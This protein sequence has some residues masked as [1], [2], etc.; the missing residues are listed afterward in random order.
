MKIRTPAFYGSGVVAFAVPAATGLVHSYQVNVDMLQGTPPDIVLGPMI[1]VLGNQ[2]LEIFLLSA[3]LTIAGAAAGANLSNI[4]PVSFE[5]DMLDGAK[6]AINVSPINL[7]AIAQPE[8]HP[9]GSAEGLA[10]N[11]PQFVFLMPPFTFHAADFTPA[12]RFVQAFLNVNYVTGA[13]GGM[14]TSVLFTI[15]ARILDEGGYHE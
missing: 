15:G 5:L 10:N 7:S 8:F 3:T 6:N 11:D 2:D 12:V 13:G 9:K 1:E 14:G 4:G